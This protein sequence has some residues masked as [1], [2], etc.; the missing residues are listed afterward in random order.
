MTF[1]DGDLN[2]L[3]TRHRT[4]RSRFTHTYNP[5]Q[6]LLHSMSIERTRRERFPGDQPTEEFRKAS[7][8]TS[9]GEMGHAP[10]S[11]QG[12]GFPSI[13]RRLILETTWILRVWLQKVWEGFMLQLRRSPPTCQVNVLLGESWGCYWGW[14][15]SNLCTKLVSTHWM[16]LS[17]HHQW[18]NVSPTW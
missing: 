6:R 11:P 12:T 15:P 17:H 18:L 14:L 2:R 13:S 10:Q 9:F 8:F 4:S 16:T 7:A 3:P 1:H 5:W